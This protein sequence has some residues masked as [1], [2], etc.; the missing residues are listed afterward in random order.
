MCLV[1]SFTPLLFSDDSR[2]GLS[3]AAGDNGGTT[4]PRLP[5]CCQQHSPCGGPSPGHLSLSHSHSSCLQAS[6]QQVSSS[7]HG[8]GSPHHFLHHVHHPAP[9]HPGTLP[10]QEPSCP[11]ERPSALPAPCAGVGSSNSSSSSNTA[12]YHD[13]VLGLLLHVQFVLVSFSCPSLLKT[14]FCPQ[15]TLPVDLS[16]SSVRSNGNSGASFHGSTSAFDPCCPV[17]TSRPPTFVSQATPGPSQPAVV[18][19][20]S[21]PMVA[22][23]GPQTQPQQPCRH[24]MHPS[25]EYIV[26]EEISNEWNNYCI[27]FSYRIL[28]HT[29]MRF[30]W[31]DIVY[32]Q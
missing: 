11:I 30:H 2:L 31:V 21:S 15:Q 26:K 27:C 28:K 9:Q 32:T 3:G 24:Y 14:S 17:S 13:Q 12:H 6:S 7:Q 22:Q 25:C 18:D 10:F 20:F 4:L 8:H 1:P 29:L 23:G 5:S 16:N 19:S